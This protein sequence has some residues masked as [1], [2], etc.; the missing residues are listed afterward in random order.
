MTK[1]D[2]LVLE[3]N[4]NCEIKSCLLCVHN[5]EKNIKGKCFLDENEERKM[6]DEE[7]EKLE[8]RGKFIDWVLEHY[9][10]IVK[11]YLGFDKE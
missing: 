6:N 2:I 5:N 9:P 1:D 10:E 4:W 11:E 3:K 8:N 7:L